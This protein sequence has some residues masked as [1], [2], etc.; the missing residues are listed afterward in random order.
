MVRVVYFSTHWDINQLLEI[1]L[2]GSFAISGEVVGVSSPAEGWGD[3]GV[4]LYVNWLFRPLWVKLVPSCHWS[5]FE[6]EGD[7]HQGEYPQIW[8][9][10]LIQNRWK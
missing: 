1:V 9:D 5:E 2:Q 10:K 6:E 7:Q 3:L 4:W 8:D